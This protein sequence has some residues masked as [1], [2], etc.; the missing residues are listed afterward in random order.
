MFVVLFKALCTFAISFVLGMVGFVL[1]AI[2][3]TGVG[4][5]LVELEETAPFVARFLGFSLIYGSAII[6]GIFGLQKG[7]KWTQLMETLRR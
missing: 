6:G 3:W 4:E 1:G 2:I 5:S 7:A